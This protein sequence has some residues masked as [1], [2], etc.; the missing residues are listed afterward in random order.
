[1]R[2]RGERKERDEKRE[3]PNRGTDTCMGERD[4]KQK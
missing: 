3:I 1:V 2:E 4:E